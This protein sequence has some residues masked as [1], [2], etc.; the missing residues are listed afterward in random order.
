[1][2]PVPASRV[3]PAK[4]WAKRGA[5]RA[6]EHNGLSLKYTDPSKLGPDQGVVAQPLQCTRCATKEEGTWVSGPR[7]RAGAQVQYDDWSERITAARLANETKDWSKVNPCLAKE[8]APC[9][10][11]GVGGSTKWCCKRSDGSSACSESTYEHERSR[12]REIERAREAAV[13][14]QAVCVR[15]TFPTPARKLYRLS[16]PPSADSCLSHSNLGLCATAASRVNPLLGAHEG[17]TRCATKEGGK[18][19]SG[20]GSVTVP[21]SAP[22]AGGPGGVI[23]GQRFRAEAQAQF[24]DDA[25]GACLR[26]TLPIFV[27]LARCPRVPPGAP[28]LMCLSLIPLS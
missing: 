9:N 20:P 8:H 11:C 19:V 24:T 10:G 26:Q 23:P 13:S 22:P 3:N 14:K 2:L 17:C 15:C 27:R 21:V 28:L 12:D 7:F 25:I 5:Q 4:R 1:L 18:W 6:V 16:P